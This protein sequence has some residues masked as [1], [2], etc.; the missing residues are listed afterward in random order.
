MICS[1]LALL[2]AQSALPPRHAIYKSIDRGLT[3]TRAGAILPGNPRVN[4]F[5][6]I[7]DQIFAGTDAG[8]YSSSDGGQTW[9]KTSVTARTVSF[10]TSDGV[11]YAGTQ[12]A[13]LLASTDDGSTWTPIGGLASRNIRS[14]LASEG[15]LYAGTDAGGVM[16]SSDRGATWSPQNAGLPP[17]SQIFAMARLHDAIFAALYAKGLYVWSRTEH[18]WSEAGGGKVQPLVLAAA[19]DTLS[20]GHNPGGIYWS[21]QPASPA[22]TKA[23]GAFGPA[24]PVWEMA[25]S[26][27]LVFAG[28][29]DGIFRSDDAGRTWSRTLRGL[30][31]NSPAV[32]FLVQGNTIYAG[33]VIPAPGVQE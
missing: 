13:G 26:H 5:G 28:V 22:W 32:S 4:S 18:R 14:L 17:L 12:T 21:E 11:V 20:V 16:L 6:A 1:I 24:A 33:V 3:W 10:V 9:R 7:K 31:A 23:I 27:K 29:A 25:S 15:Q 30:P 8:I 19:G 2:L